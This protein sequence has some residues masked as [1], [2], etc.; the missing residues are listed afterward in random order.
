LYSRLGLTL[1]ITLSACGSTL[2]ASD[3]VTAHAAALAR[4]RFTA[5]DAGKAVVPH[6]LVTAMAFGPDGIIYA[7]GRYM[8]PDTNPGALQP[9]AAAGGV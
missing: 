6:V 1:L 2:V 3:G 8:A 5:L 9:V 7:G 4:I